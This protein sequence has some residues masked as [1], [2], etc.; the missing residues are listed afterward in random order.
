MVARTPSATSAKVVSVVVMSEP[1]VG[2]G[3]FERVHVD[4]AQGG[5]QRLVGQSGQEAVD[6]ALEVGD[7]ALDLLGEAHV[8]EAPGV[9]A[10]LLPGQVGEVLL[11]DGRYPR[12]VAL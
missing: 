4:L 1:Q 7:A 11:R 12:V 10:Q 9:Q 3:S 8:L 2:D 5:Q 6:G